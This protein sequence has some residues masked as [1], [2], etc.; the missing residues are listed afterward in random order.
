LL[1]NVL[2][3]KNLFK[4]ELFGVKMLK[5]LKWLYMIFILL[6]VFT[7][8]ADPDPTI[9]PS[10]E[11]L[12]PVQIDSAI[13]INNCAKIYWQTHKDAVFYR[14]YTNYNTKKGTYGLALETTKITA[15]ISNI[16]ANQLY[17]FDIA[18]V[19]TKGEE[20]RTYNPVS[21]MYDT[22]PPTIEFELYSEEIG[23]YNTNYIQTNSKYFPLHF[24]AKD[25]YEIKWN[26]AN[27][28]YEGRTDYWI[29]YF[30]GSQTQK[31]WSYGTFNFHQ[32]TNTLIASA[33]DISGHTTSRTFIVY[34]DS[35]P[36][37]ITNIV[38]STNQPN[39]GEVTV[40]AYASG[41]IQSSQSFA[42]SMN[43]YHTFKFVDKLGN[44]TETNII[45]D[46]LD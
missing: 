21:V 42:Y 17:Y 34:Y 7:A 1:K 46:W 5:Q 26:S 39:P 8:C 29:L 35:I 19:N 43:Q 25:N 12:N 13:Y 9:Y 37:V 23:Y 14:V 2:S 16:A 6:V 27:V 11:A 18:V 33:S 44:T 38:Y 22:L 41:A 3:N 32:G 40:T 10:Y 31:E 30:S 15:A 45:V 24:K 36:P 4:I 28:D 20:R